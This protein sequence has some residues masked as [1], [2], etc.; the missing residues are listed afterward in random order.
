MIA[1]PKEGCR[2]LIILMG[3]LG[4]VVR[5][6]SLPSQIKKNLQD[7][8][9]TWLVEPSCHKIVS[10]NKFI[11]RVVIFQ[12]DRQL[13]A[14]PE[15]YRQLRSERFDV[16]LDMQRHFKS[17]LF[18]FL[19]GAEYRLGFHRN[20][21]KEFNHFFNTHFIS[22]LPYDVPKIN[23]YYNFLRE[24]GIEPEQNPD[25][26]LSYIKNLAEQKEML[27]KIESP[28]IGIVLGSSWNSKD[29]PRG[30]YISLIEKLIKQGRHRMLLLGDKSQ[31]V[32]AE[33]ITTHFEHSNLINFAGKTNLQDLIALID[34]SLLCVGP[35][36]GPGHIAGA[37]GKPYISLFGPTDPRLTA[38]L[39]SE[40]LVIRAQLGCM[41]CYRRKCPGLNKLCMRLITVEDVLEKIN[42]T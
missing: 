6:L 42:T 37:L 33:E 10:L 22:D 25:F 19:S 27:S 40:K 8:K 18:S 23:H 29:W 38:P 31:S 2:I 12:R 28:Y 5:G 17:G 30:R 20:K 1:L 21:T 41:P 39:G 24:L 11:D 16:V 34:G 35:D 26:G 36:S 4:D 15:L 13:F 7:S 9:I 14:L 3:S 32:L